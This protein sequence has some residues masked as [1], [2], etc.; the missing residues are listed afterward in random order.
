MTR[1]KM[2]NRVWMLREVTKNVGKPTTM[3]ILQCRCL[4]CGKGIQDWKWGKELTGKLWTA[5][6][7][8]LEELWMRIQ[9]IR[10][11][12]VRREKGTGWGKRL[13]TGGPWAESG[14][15]TLLGSWVFALVDREQMP[16]VPAYL[17]TAGSPSRHRESSCLS[18]PLP[19]R[20]YGS[21]WSDTTLH[22]GSWQ[23]PQRRRE[24]T[25]VLMGEGQPPG[26]HEPPLPHF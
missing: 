13:K 9:E 17:G 5:H 11:W 25:F 18:Q 2:T 15:D 3:R 26:N 1:I 21:H 4:P 19:F 7:Q 8:V 16:L 10:R 20:C 22:A 14:P 12:Q 24:L 6:V 23:K